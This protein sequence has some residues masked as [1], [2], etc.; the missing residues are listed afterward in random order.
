LLSRGAQKLK[1]AAKTAT[2]VNEGNTMTGASQD[3]C[4]HITLEMHVK[5]Y[6]NKSRELSILANQSETGHEKYD[7][8][9][10]KET[11][12]ESQSICYRPS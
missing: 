2:K 3:T 9:K 11:E 8:R 6:D 1:M 7:K 12:L 4:M 10:L 5:F